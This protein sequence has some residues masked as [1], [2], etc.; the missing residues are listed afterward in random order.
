MSSEKSGLVHYTR[1]DNIDV[2]EISNMERETVHTWEKLVTGQLAD[3]TRPAKRLY[4][5][6]QVSTITTYAMRTVFRVRSHP[7]TRFS[8]AAV[9]TT[10]E[11][12]A[13][14]TNMILRITPGGNFKIF[15]SETEAVAW[16]HQ[17]VPDETAS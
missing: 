10:S 7:N 17:Q 3:M 16:L 13:D 9:I 4:D 2:F 12:V 5:L 1:P 15:T 6:R 8:Y 11:R 14:L